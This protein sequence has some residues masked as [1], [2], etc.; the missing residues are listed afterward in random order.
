MT[1]LIVA[2]HLKSCGYGPT[3]DPASVPTSKVSPLIENPIGIKIGPKTNLHDL[4]VTIKKLNPRNNKGKIVLMITQ[5]IL[6]SLHHLIIRQTYLW[7][8]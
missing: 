2:V 5:I 3:G 8:S 1:P 6:V 7:N 4:T